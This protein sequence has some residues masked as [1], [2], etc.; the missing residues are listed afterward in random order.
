MASLPIPPDAARVTTL[1]NVATMPAVARVLGRFDR[2]HLA[3]F[4]AVA[5][6]LADALDGD[7]DLE[8]DDH[9]GV[10]DEDGVNVATNYVGVTTG[11]RPGDDDDAEPEEAD[12]TDQRGFYRDRIRRTRCD[13]LSTRYTDRWRLRPPLPIVRGGAGHD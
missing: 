10:N 12:E 1:P 7:P 3:G 2:D 8:E 11:E 6:D 4:I 9:S 13:N 5:I